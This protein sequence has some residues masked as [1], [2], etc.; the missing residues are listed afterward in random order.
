MHDWGDT[1]RVWCVRLAAEQLY[2]GVLRSASL[3]LDIT[4]GFL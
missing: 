4:S 1:H 3:P 2:V